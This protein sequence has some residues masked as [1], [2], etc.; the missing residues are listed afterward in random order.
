MKRERTIIYVSLGVIALIFI[1]LSIFYLAHL[2]G[3]SF[4]RS[5]DEQILSPVGA[6]ELTAY[7]SDAYRIYV[8]SDVDHSWFDY[9]FATMRFSTGFT[10][11]AYWGKKTNDVFVLSGDVGLY[12]YFYNGDG[13]WSSD[14]EYSIRLYKDEN[15]ELKARKTNGSRRTH[16]E[17][18][19]D[20][21]AYDIGNIPD[22]AL[23]YLK[24]AYN[25]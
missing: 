3:F 25:V 20:A 15:G 11:Q 21:G 19:D 2:F 16:L 10:V 6:Y 24:K 9:A 12:C 14:E 22:E 17:G 18:T 5:R 13:T 4:V 23:D 8:I 1:F 7:D